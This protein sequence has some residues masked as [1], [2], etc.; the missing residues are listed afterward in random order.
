MSVDLSVYLTP[1]VGPFPASTRAILMR[2]RT[3]AVGEAY[4]P[5]NFVRFD[6]KKRL[7]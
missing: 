6:G 5:L 4:A 2:Q 7:L 1:E 3:K